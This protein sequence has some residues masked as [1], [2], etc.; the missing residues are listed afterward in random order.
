VEQEAIVDW[1]GVIIA[2]EILEEQKSEQEETKET[3]N[4]LQ[5]QSNEQPPVEVDALQEPV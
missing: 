1:S 5:S 2:D 3:S 4:E